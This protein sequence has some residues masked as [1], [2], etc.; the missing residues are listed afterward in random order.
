ML[1]TVFTIALALATR[2]NVAAPVQSWLETKAEDHGAHLAST[3]T[4]AEA[5][6]AAFSPLQQSTSLLPHLPGGDAPSDPSISAKNVYAFDR[7]TGKVLYQ[8]DAHKQVAMASITKVMTAVVVLDQEPNLDKQVKI[9]SD[10]IRVEGSNMSLLPGEVLTVRELLYG[11]MVNSANDAAQ[12][13]AKEVGGGSISNFVRLMNQKADELGL[14]NSHYQ[15]ST[16]LDQEGHYSSAYDIAQLADYA[17]DKPE[18]SQMVSTK[19]M[20][21]VSHDYTHTRHYLENTDKLLAG[22]EGVYAGKT[23]F[24]D[25]AG[26]CLVSAA[27]SNGHDVINVVL[28]SEDRGGDTQKL[29][30]WEF[31]HYVW[32]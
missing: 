7:A 30:A 1:A 17:F 25:N 18:L 21:V 15:N 4:V 23:G 8:K 9:T 16:G 5:G 20:T 2:L 28:G 14:E 13:L 3:A 26:L 27:R 6:G 22:V 24:T 19:T 10:A 12:V 31:A 11:L 32:K 29:L